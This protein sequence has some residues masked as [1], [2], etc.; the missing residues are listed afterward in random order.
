MVVIDSDEDVDKLSSSADIY[1]KAFAEEVAVVA[2]A[3]A[4]SELM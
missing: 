1:V 4:T 2:N 3:L